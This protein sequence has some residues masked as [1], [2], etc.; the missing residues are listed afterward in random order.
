MKYFLCVEKK[1]RIDVYVNVNYDRSKSP[2]FWRRPGG[3]RAGRK[4]FGQKKAQ[5]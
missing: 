2:A 3:W 5:S 1:P 4:I